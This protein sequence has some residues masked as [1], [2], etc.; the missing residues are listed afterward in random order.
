MCI[1]KNKWTKFTPTKK[2]LDAVKYVKTV[3]ELDYWLDKI[4]YISDDKD[5][6]QTPEETLNRGKGDCDDFARLALDILVRI[7]KRDDVRFIIYAGYNSK[8]KYNAHAVC[9]FPYYGS[10]SVFS[11]H[12]YYA[13]RDDY[14]DIGHIYY[15]KGLKYMSV[16]NDKGKVIQWKVKLFGVF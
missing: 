13:K 10:Y 2:Y 9:V 3:T 14:I 11:N 6:W 4:K 7:R 8:D 5:Y 15:P 1:F 12:M 16:R